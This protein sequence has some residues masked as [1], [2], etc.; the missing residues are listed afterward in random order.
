M[1]SVTSNGVSKAI[2]YATT[3]QLTGG[4]WIDGKPI[5]RKVVDFGAL[6][7]A[8]QKSVNH[9]IS[10]LGQ[11]IKCDVI[12][13]NGSSYWPLPYASLNSIASQVTCQVNRTTVQIATGTNNSETAYFIIEYTKT[14]D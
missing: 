1:Q 8:S 14:T 7:N 2:S 10:N 13:T 5:Y 11:V 6:P 9:G 3:E 12:S 4:K